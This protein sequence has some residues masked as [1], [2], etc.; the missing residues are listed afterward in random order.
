MLDPTKRRAFDA[1]LKADFELDPNAPPLDLLSADMILNTA[2][3]EPV[4]AIPELLPAGLSILG[5]KA[6][7]GK[8]WLALQ[9]AHA[10][11]AGGMALGRRVEQGPVCYLALEDPPRRLKE[12]MLK[13]HWRPGLPADFMALGH[14]ETQIGDLRN[15]GGERLSRQIEHRGYRLVVIDTL[16]RACVG[17]QNDVQAMTAA[18]TPLQE[19]SHTRN[20]CILLVDH[21]GKGGGFE[22]D[23]ITDILG[24]TAKGAMADSI[25]GLYR[26]SGKAGAKLRIAG[27]EVIEQTLALTF[28]GLTGCWQCEGD[29]NELEL[30]GR[31]QELLAAIEELGEPTAGQ[32]AK[33]VGRDRGNV[34]K[35]LQDLVNASKIQRLGKGR[36][37][38]YAPLS[39]DSLASIDDDEE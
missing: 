1:I 15:G 33:F 34:Y 3:P 22:P 26:E 35:E 20:C 13:Q 32:V 5:G 18:L 37:T 28:D 31:R 23:A 24:S 6:K 8:S 14:F 9:V 19:I 29:A 39:L 17:D 7:R 38:K 25:W 36:D 27:R 16:S 12:R 4:W 30:T 10:I 21:H 11:A 2:W